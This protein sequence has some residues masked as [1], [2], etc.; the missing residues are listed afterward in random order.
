ML[1]HYVI[2]RGNSNILAAAVVTEITWFCNFKVKFGLNYYSNLCKNVK[3]IR[4]KDNLELGWEAE[5]KLLQ[6]KPVKSDFFSWSEQGYIFILIRFLIGFS[7]LD[8]VL[9]YVLRQWD[10]NLCQ[11]MHN[12]CVCLWKGLVLKVS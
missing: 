8:I 3:I 4:R 2:W 11:S 12:I 5:I 7:I 10:R 6:P 1:L 9:M